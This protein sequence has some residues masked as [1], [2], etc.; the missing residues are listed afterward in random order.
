MNVMESEIKNPYFSVE[1]SSSLIK[2]IQTAINKI[3]KN[4][5]DLEF[6]NLENY[7][8]SISY[9]LG[10][11]KRASIEA[12]MEEIAEAPFKMK[13]AGFISVYSEYYG[14]HIIGVHLEHTSDFLYSQEFLKE[15]L[16]QD[17]EE[18]K[19][20]EFEGGFSAH[21]SLVVI[22]GLKEGESELIARYLELM[23]TE[24]GGQEIYGEK[25]CIYNES[26]EKLAE[27]LFHKDK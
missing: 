27:K 11:A 4:D 7:H 23:M 15:Y 25:F 9:I 5:L 24:L 20:R 10:M 16:T 22:K 21:I 18:I 1:L 14:G 26:R 13:I 6:T 19:I 8:I 3:L 12:A 2:N 17:N